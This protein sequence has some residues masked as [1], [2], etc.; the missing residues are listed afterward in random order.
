MGLIEG[1]EAPMTIDR[2]GDVPSHVGSPV[3]VTRGVVKAFQSTS[4]DT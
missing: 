1:Y 3:L 2:A 4:T